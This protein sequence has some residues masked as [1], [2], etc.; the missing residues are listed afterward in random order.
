MNM[1]RIVAG[2]SVGTWL[3][4]GYLLYLVA[5]VMG[6]AAW[7][8][9]YGLISSNPHRS[10]FSDKLATAH[11]ILYNLGVVGVTWPMGY[12]G[13]I[14]GS[15]L[16]AGRAAEIHPAIVGFVLPIGVSVAIGVLSTI[17]GAINILLSLMKEARDQEK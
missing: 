11:F 3:T 5:G 9:I 14:G 12:V 4:L 1:A 13:F 6:T 8:G 17:I 7:G 10:N 16:L 15:L 2:G